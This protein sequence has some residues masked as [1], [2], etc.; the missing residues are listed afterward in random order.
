MKVGW[1]V[2]RMVLRSGSFTILSE[3]GGRFFF[4]P[5]ASIQREEISW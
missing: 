1:R 5:T 4:L 2:E 3:Y